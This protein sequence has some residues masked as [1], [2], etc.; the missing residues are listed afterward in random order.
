[1]NAMVEQA[2]ISKIRELSAQQLA[3]VEDFV[4]F[5]AAKSRKRAAFDRLLAIAPALEAAGVESMG[6]AEV[7]AEIAAAR[8][9][10]HPAKAT[11]ADRS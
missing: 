10:R 11:G 4:E 6:E 1:M 3:E 2:L 8:A 7:A 9:G 5:L